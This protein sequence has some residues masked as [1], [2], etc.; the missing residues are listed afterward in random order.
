MQSNWCRPVHRVPS[1]ARGEI[2]TL[3]ERELPRGLSL[4]LTVTVCVA[5]TELVLST[6]PFRA[7]TAGFVTPRAAKFG[8]FR[9]VRDYFRD[10]APT[11][12]RLPHPSA[13][14]RFDPSPPRPVTAAL[15]PERRLCR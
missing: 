11:P 4:R 7:S 15:G 8:G 13:G 2:R 5:G 14:G 6:W 1:S 12:K 3:T 9:V 10:Y